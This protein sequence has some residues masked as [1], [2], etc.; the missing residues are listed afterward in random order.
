M[1]LQKTVFGRQKIKPNTFIGGVSA[2]INTPAL[3][4]SKLGITASRIKGFSIIGANI[5]F[6][7]VG[8]NYSL[9]GS[10]FSGDTNITYYHDLD[11]LVTLITV[12]C[13]LNCINFTS[14]KFKNATTIN[15]TAFKG[16]ALIGTN[17]D[18]SSVITT[19]LESFSSLVPISES[20]INLP[21][22]INLNSS[23]T[24]N[25]D[26]ALSNKVTFNIPLFFKTSNAGKP[27]ANLIGSTLRA[28]NIN[29][30]GHV[31][32][33]TYNTDIG[34][35]NGVFA[36]KGLLA[37]RL[38]IGSGAIIN[39][40]SIGLD[41]QFKVLINYNLK[42][43]TNDNYIT[44][45]FDLDGLTNLVPQFCFQNCINFRNAKLKNVTNIN[46]YAFKNSGFVG[47]D[48]DFSSVN[49]IAL[50]GFR[51]NAS[52]ELLTLPVVTNLGGSVVNNNVFTNIKLGA[53]ITV[54][55]ALQTANAGAPDGD[56]VYASGTRGATIIYI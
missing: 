20:V 19:N 22:L 35:Y 17:C 2:T 24:F 37:E 26:I 36:N 11:G 15:N 49:F 47:N 44:H 1:S 31:D 33:G 8:G 27:H 4:A 41:I 14:A 43:W 32:D 46:N 12:S 52:L 21:N 54:P 5:Q 51:D 18:F 40:N 53:T 9:P 6:A 25:G 3:A 48:S 28:V 10:M 56:L 50:E 45:Y 55:I 13:F 7:V 38:G 34:G 42:V 29:Y 30:I 16:S 39:Y 23:G